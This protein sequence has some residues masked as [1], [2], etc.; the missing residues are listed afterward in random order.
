MSTKISRRVFFIFME[1]NTEI[2]F[3]LLNEI[4]GTPYMKGFEIFKMF[5]P[6]IKI[7][8]CRNSVG[9]NSISQSKQK[10]TANSKNLQNNKKKSY[11]NLCSLLV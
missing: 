9:C 1:E 10:N 8:M 5:N 2:G 7:S 11:T 4:L 3:F 6:W